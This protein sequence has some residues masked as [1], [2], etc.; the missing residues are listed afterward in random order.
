MSALH[1]NGSALLGSVYVSDMVTWLQSFDKEIQLNTS[2]FL[3]DLMSGMILRSEAT[4]MGF[5]GDLISLVQDT[6]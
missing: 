4:S 6:S 5:T 2:Y 3:N 1:Q